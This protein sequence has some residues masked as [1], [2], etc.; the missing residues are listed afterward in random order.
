MSFLPFHSI[1]VRT[2][3][4]L[5]LK[6]NINWILAF[7]TTGMFSGTASLLIYV[8]Y[9]REENIKLAGYIL[10]SGGFALFYLAFCFADAETEK[11][12][13]AEI[14][15]AQ[16]LA[17]ENP[18][19]P[20]FA[21]ELAR[22]KLESYL[23]RNLKQV[24]SIFWL[25]S[26]VMLSGFSFIMY[27]LYHAVNNPDKLPVS[28]VAA[29]SGVII[30]FI[31]GSLLLIYRSILAQTKTYV[32]VLERINAVGMAVHVIESIPDEH[33]EQK[34]LSKAELAKQLLTLYSN[35]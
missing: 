17:H 14:F 18:E 23:D 27:G 25:T 33:T 35:R 7:A 15:T 26:L 4:L 31:G 30:S 11:L 13:Q 10:L 2:I 12:Q 24:N 20:Q 1:L 28:I 19:K 8:F 29:S 5:D 3:N 22:V 34:N 16:E 21:W 32:S 6:L 9:W